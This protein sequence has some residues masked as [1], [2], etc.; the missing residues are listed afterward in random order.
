MQLLLNYGTVNNDTTVEHETQCQLSNSYACNNKGI[1]GSGVFCG[2]AS[3]VMSCN[4]GRT[5][6][7]GVLC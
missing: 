7:G 1:L 2:S 4:S 5:V 3:L 6:G